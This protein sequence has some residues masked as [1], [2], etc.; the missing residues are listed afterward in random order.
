M[1]NG[2]NL[3]Y[4]LRATHRI[5][6]VCKNPWWC[7]TVTVFQCH[8]V[9]SARTSVRVLTPLMRWPFWHQ[10]CSQVSKGHV[11]VTMDWNMSSITLY[12][13]ALSRFS[14]IISISTAIFFQICWVT[15]VVRQ[16][17]V[18]SETRSLVPAI[19]IH[20]PV[21]GNVVVFCEMIKWVVKMLYFL[22]SGPP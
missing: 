2:F 5:V 9:M 22:P 12:V 7:F 16:C 14:C 17:C 19:D 18:Q 15:C 10:L 4:S 11:S 8:I 3:S 6:G 21:I 1:P 20:G 13:Y